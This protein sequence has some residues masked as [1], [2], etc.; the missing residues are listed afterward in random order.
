MTT[1]RLYKTYNFRNKDPVIDELRTLKKD[2]KMS[3]ADIANKS[4][5]SIGTLK[6]WFD[7][8]VRRPQS[9]TVEAVGRALGYKRGWVK[10]GG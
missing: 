7:G 5:V 3:D 1:L 10:M 6:G 8:P 4:G 2:V 9:A